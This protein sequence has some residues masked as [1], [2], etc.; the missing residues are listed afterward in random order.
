MSAWCTLLMLVPGLD[1]LMAA[2]LTWGRTK[3]RADWSLSAPGVTD[4]SPAPPAPTTPISSA[5]TQSAAALRRLEALRAD[6]TL[7]EEQFLRMKAR[8][9]L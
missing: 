6:G 3:V 5:S 8:H 1:L 7:S 2:Y 9:G 4:K